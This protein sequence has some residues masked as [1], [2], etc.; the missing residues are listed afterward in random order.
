MIKLMLMAVGAGILLNRL[1]RGLNL[2]G[3]V[4]LIIAAILIPNIL[5]L[6]ARF[7][8]IEVKSKHMLGLA[9]L[10]G[11][12][13]MINPIIGIAFAAVATAASLDFLKK[14]PVLGIVLS[15]LDRV[16]IVVGS[17]FAVP[18]MVNYGGEGR[19]LT[20]NFGSRGTAINKNLL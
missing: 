6:M 14:I 5:A 2:R 1:T 16:M 12:L 11:L 8:K 10:A 15:I 18:V 9:A 13:V 7:T 20:A 4:L 17:I 3:P 19:L